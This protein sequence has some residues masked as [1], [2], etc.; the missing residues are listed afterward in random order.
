MITQELERLQAS[1]TAAERARGFVIAPDPRLSR[2]H[3]ASFDARP[4]ASRSW[5]CAARRSWE[6]T[7]DLLGLRAFWRAFFFPSPNNPPLSAS[8]SASVTALLTCILTAPPSAIDHA[9]PRRA[10]WW[11][12]CCFW[13]SKQWGDL[14]QLLPAYLERQFGE[15]VPVYRVHSINMW[16]CM[17]GPSLVAGLTSHIEALRCRTLA[18]RR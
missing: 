4:F 12:V 9:R 1:A 11:S 5:S 8:S 3:S 7:R 18:K 6:S 15:S 2:G 14:D 16:I 10:L 17:L 13:I